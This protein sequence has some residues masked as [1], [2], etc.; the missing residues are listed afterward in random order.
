[1]TNAG[2]RHPK[3]P[4]QMITPVTR[5]LRDELAAA[6]RMLQSLGVKLETGKLTDKE[7]Y[8]TTVDTLE[9]LTLAVLSATSGPSLTRPVGLSAARFDM[10]SGQPLAQHVTACVSYLRGTASGLLAQN[11]FQ[12]Y[13]SRETDTALDMLK[14]LNGMLLSG[15]LKQA[16]ADLEAIRKR[17]VGGLIVAADALA[18]AAAVREDLPEGEPVDD[19]SDTPPRRLSREERLAQSAVDN[20]GG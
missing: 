18:K 1:M 15:I 7:H 2:N 3:A 10:A 13:G 4:K 14:Q 9:A 20:Y 19:V 6:G 5:K 12:N 16:E 17:G 8:V 11:S